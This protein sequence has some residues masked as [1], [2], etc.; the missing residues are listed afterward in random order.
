LKGGKGERVGRG[1][2]RGRSLGWGCGGW[3]WHLNQRNR[4][5]L[6][7]VGKEESKYQLKGVL[8]FFSFCLFFFLQVETRLQDSVSNRG[9][10]PSP[11]E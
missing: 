6:G 11:L 4:R 8:G 1:R 2:W 10:I 5:V 3:L 9:H 7:G